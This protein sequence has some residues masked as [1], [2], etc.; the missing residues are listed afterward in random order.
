MKNIYLTTG[1]INEV[2]NELETSFK[3][4]LNSN[5]NEFNLTLDSDLS[6]GNIEGISFINGITSIQVTISFSDDTLL[7]IE[8]S[9]KSSLLFAYCT[10]GSINHSFGVSGHKST[11]RKHQ[12]AVMT[13]SRSINTILHFKKNIP[14][15]FSLIKVEIEDSVN[16]PIISRL[17]KTFLNKQQNYSYLGIQNLKI[18]KEF[19]QLDSV[20]E[21]GMTGLIM[22]KE[23]I[24]SI[25]TIEIDHHTDNLIKMSRAIKRSALNQMN[26][27]KKITSIIKNYS[28]E[29]IYS[30]VSTSK[31]QNLY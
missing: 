21:Q 8:S 23:I 1:T 15:K 13:S 20:T 6:K 7:S 22:K 17:K 11:L 16:N 12:S 27:L 26:E 25:L 29:A 18:M 28:L 2:F 4:N 14:I 10:E 30:K 9:D 24:Q 19:D 5:N 31:K 3:G